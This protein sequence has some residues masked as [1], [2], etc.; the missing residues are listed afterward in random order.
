MPATTPSITSIKA[1]PL[2]Q[3]T[4]APS[5]SHRTRRPVGG[6]TIRQNISVERMQAIAAQFFESPYFAV[7]DASQHRKT[8]GYNG[9]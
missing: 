3:F 4:R 8:Q 6:K 9:A 1:T 7:A 5:G 2:A